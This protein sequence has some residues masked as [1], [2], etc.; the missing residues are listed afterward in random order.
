MRVCLPAV[1]I[2]ILIPS[3]ATG[4]TTTDDGLRAMLLGDYPGAVRILRPLADDASK[5]DAVAQFFMAVL[6]ESGRGVERNR[7]RACGLFESAAKPSN[8]FREQASALVSAMRDEMGLM[9]QFCTA[10]TQWHSL[11]PTSFTLGPDHRIEITESGSTIYY[12]GSEHRTYGSGLPGFVPLPP[13]YTPLDVSRPVA[14]R[15]H[16]IEQFVWAPDVPDKPSTW[17]LWW[18]LGEVV[19]G[20]SLLVTTDRNMVTVIGTQPPATFDL[21]GVV[22]VRV[23]GDGEAEWQILS[24][25][26]P[27]S[28]IIP[29]REPR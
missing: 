25:P 27:R 3:L 22:R 16:F 20:E 24:G 5:P 4:Q 7:L 28:G 1:L 12:N 18:M 26:N 21:A 11:P 13:R 15:R 10:G 23:N 9:A 17:T 6:Y 8:P 14:A 29:R 2:L 19:G